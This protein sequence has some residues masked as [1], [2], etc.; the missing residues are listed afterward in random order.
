MSCAHF[1][2]WL[3]HRLTEY[4]VIGCA[5][6]LKQKAEFLGIVRPQ[7][8]LHNSEMLNSNCRLVLN[9]KIN[10]TIEKWKTKFV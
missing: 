10:I 8:L 4:G 2:F 1:N 7:G 6:S 3:F 5:M 9:K